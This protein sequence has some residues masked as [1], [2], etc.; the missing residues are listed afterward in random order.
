MSGSSARDIAVQFKEQGITL[1]GRREQSVAKELEKVIPVASTTG[2]ALLALV[3]VIG[4]VLGL[5]GKAAAIVVG[6]AT[7]FS[8]LE[9]IS[10]DYQQTGGQSALAQVLGAPGRF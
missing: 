5:K 1:T 6:V 3:T 9:L 7:G 2:A 4:E 10:M 8:L